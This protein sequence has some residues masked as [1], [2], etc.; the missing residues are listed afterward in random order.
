KLFK[1]LSAKLAF[2]YDPSHTFIKNLHRP[3]YYY[4]QDLSTNP[5]TYTKVIGNSENGAPTYS[6]LNESYA[7]A[8]R[9]TYQ[10]YLNYKG[11]FGKN[12]VTGLLVVE[13]HKNKY[14]NLSA[15][16]THFAINSDQ[17]NLGPSN[18]NY[19]SNGGADSTSTRLGFVYK[20]G[21]NYSGKYL[22]QVSGRYDG[23][24]YFAPGQRWG[25][26][27][28]VSAGWVLSR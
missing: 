12:H 19:Y 27:P 6:Y 5:P 14:N 23:S 18:K 2:A 8:Q 25:F 7:R 16:R 3:Y 4:T 24:Y 13:A 10:A 15:G 1:G 26:F 17:L 20:V 11:D 9:F 22:I 21:Y 28:A